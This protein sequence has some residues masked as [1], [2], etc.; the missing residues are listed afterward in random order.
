MFYSGGKFKKQ[1]VNR[2]F[3][4]K[5]IPTTD[6]NTRDRH[7]V[8][9][10]SVV[11]TTNKSTTS[12][13]TRTRSKSRSRSRSKSRSRKDEMYEFNSDSENTDDTDIKSEI[14]ESEY[15]N[16]DDQE[17]NDDLFEKTDYITTSINNNPGKIVKYS[18][19]FIDNELSY[20][21][22]DID[23]EISEFEMV[24]YRINTKNKIPFLEFLLHYD[25]DACVF[26]QYKKMKRS[27]DTLKV[28]LDN[29]I[30]QLFTSK[31]RYKG[32]FHSDTSGK[33]RN[34]KYY[35]F[36]EIYFNPDYKPYFVSLTENNKDNW[37]WVCATEIINN[38]YYLNI[39]IDATVVDIF[40]DHPHIMIL[41]TDSGNIELPVVLYTGANFCYTET[42]SKF[43]LR[44][45]PIT[46]R[47]GP[48]Y[49]FTDFTHSFRWGCYDYKNTV[50]LGD[51]KINNGDKHISG[52]ITRY[53]VFTGKM[54]TVYNDDEY[55]NTL[56]KQY[57]ENK[58]LFEN[59]S[60]TKDMKYLEY[61]DRSQSF[62][63]YDYSWTNE[64][65]TIYNGR[66]DLDKSNA[67]GAKSDDYNTVMPFWCKYDYDQFEQLTYY[68][69]DTSN[70]PEKY[71]LVYDSYRIF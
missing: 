11:D 21:L 47:Y 41:E 22:N 3:M 39:C 55:D 70:I 19:P 37:F 23:D 60:V 34:G 8:D 67:K 59:V 61:L 63:S 18:Y 9:S 15:D 40:T 66:Y 2:I 1:S 28:Q 52:G 24:I 49:Y 69:V 12:H 25:S 51:S 44:R 54:K 30:K 7:S 6:D 71:D 50:L 45:E 29:V 57:K 26:T 65:N 42:I 38:K 43:G 58:K 46:S 5:S 33:D 35:I 31:F 68:C 32:Y 27:T 53:A 14:S 36:Y 4:N 56:I 64:Y 10:E 48:F 17:G 13:T 20:Q 62:H 16:D